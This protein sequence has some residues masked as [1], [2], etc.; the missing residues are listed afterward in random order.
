[1]DVLDDT[2]A[3]YERYNACA[4]QMEAVI[5]KTMFVGGV[6][7]PGNTLAEDR[8]ALEILASRSDVDRNRI[9]CCGLSLGG[10]RSA[11][12]AGST[13]GIAAAVVV[14][15]MTTWNDFVSHIAIDHTWMAIVPG[16]SQFMDFPD[17]MG[18]HAPKP[19]MVCSCTNDPLFTQTEVQKAQHSLNQIYR[20]AGSPKQFEFTHY[21]GPHRFDKTMQED[22][23]TWLDQ[24]L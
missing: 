8:I 24:H 9:G 16:I 20:K 19:A 5:A 18:M 2:I 17:I 21:Q 4:R 3:G 11:Y 22:V 14:G 13:E 6:T 23:F 15:F 7:W 12:L 1:M 10:L